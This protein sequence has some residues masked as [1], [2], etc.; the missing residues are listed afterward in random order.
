M[1]EL[2]EI[3]R[4]KDD[5]EFADLLNRLR[6]NSLTQNDK[7]KLDMHVI[8]PDDAEYFLNAPHLFAE[9]YFMHC[10]NEN[11]INNLDTERVTI[12]CHD[13]L[14]APKLSMVKQEEAINKLPT[15]PNKTANLHCSL[16][17]V[18]GMIYDLT[19][20]VNTEDGLANSA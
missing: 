17:I 3:M 18:I 11:I 14:V 13:S 7:K 15:D 1:F 8:K 2:T 20:N 12:S 5:L 4:Q 10:F 6:K 19:V 9:N 16:T